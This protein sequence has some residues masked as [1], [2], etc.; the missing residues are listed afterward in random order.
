[1]TDSGIGRKYFCGINEK[2]MEQ[3]PVKLYRQAVLYKTIQQHVYV[4]LPELVQRI[5]EA[6]QDNGYGS[7]ISQ[8][9][10]QRDI[11]EMNATWVSIS[12]DKSRRGYYIPQDETVEGMLERL[13]EHVTLLSA[14]RSMDALSGYVLPEQR[15]TTGIEHLPVLVAALKNNVKVE[16]DYQKF[17]DD[18][19]RYFTAEP[20]FLKEF[21]GRWYLLAKADGAATLKTWA[22]ER[23]SRLR[24]T[25]RHFERVE[26]DV[27]RLY[28]HT[29]GIYANEALPVE[30][31]A[32]SFTP[33]AG[34]YLLSRPLHGSQV[35]LADNVEEIR[36][37]VNVKITNDF[38]MELLSQ[39][40]KMTVLAPQHLKERFRDIYRRAIE[41]MN[42]V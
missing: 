40:D 14:L 39:T 11:Q 31:V 26:V 6:L 20:Y 4:G 16:F 23:I 3:I 34:R 12:Y 35:V 15:R 28:A 33:K 41:R 17:T 29:F 37:K 38:M 36:I 30:E 1:M 25:G 2:D 7:G 21:S 27:A 5:Q 18:C 19:P 22:L 42:N 10:I 9:T 24:Q 32:L 8:R 13:F